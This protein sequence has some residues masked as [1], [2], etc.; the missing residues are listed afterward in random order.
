M[1]AEHDMALKKRDDEID[2][3]KDEN[4]RK[5]AQIVELNERV[6]ALETLVLGQR[7]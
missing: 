5:E 4:N 2:A 1:K 7:R 3:L 6:A